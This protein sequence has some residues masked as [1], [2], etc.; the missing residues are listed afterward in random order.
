LTSLPNGIFLDTIIFLLQTRLI[1]LVMG[2]MIKMKQ[3]LKVGLRIY[4]SVRSG[5]STRAPDCR[6]ERI[7]KHPD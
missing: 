7:A 5:D 4:L 1:V 6:G 2:N 3:K